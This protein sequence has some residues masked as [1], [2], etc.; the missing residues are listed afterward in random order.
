M[1]ILE[2][3]SEQFVIANGIRLHYVE[4]TGEAG[5]WRPPIILLHSG[6]GSGHCW[7]LVGP[8]LAAAGFH[9]LAP[10][11]R[12]RGRSDRPPT[13]YDL[14][15]IAEDVFS[16]IQAVCHE[17]VVVVG[18][19]YGGYVALALGAIYPNLLSKLVLV[20]GGIWS[21]EGQSWE[22]FS[23]DMQ[24]V[25]WTYPSL[26]AYLE[27]QRQGATLFWSPEVARALATTVQTDPDGTVREC[28]TPT[29]WEQTLRSMW[30]YRP[31][32]L[33]PH[34]VCPTLVI[35][36]E[37]PASLPKPLRDQKLAMNERFL[38]EALAGLRA[39]R[40]QVMEQTHHEVPFHKPVELANLIIS[41]LRAA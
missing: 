21:A 26:S 41:F 24:Q 28:M 10:D 8:H 12:G 19:S 35:V 6:L 36:T 29:A 13:G 14:R 16:F 11:L 34:I 38:P 18:H 1:S 17:R 32:Q 22:Q 5:G 25:A 30:R 33:Y 4:W 31:E 20:D 39:C 9:T 7:D 2:V 3:S 40:I 37:L 23:L 27:A 15:T